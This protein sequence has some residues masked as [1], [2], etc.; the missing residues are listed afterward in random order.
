MQVR[1]PQGEYLITLP[2]L[3][4]RRG[5][6]N[7]LSRHPTE[8]SP[9]RPLTPAQLNLLR[10]R[11][12]LTARRRWL[13]KNKRHLMEQAQAKATTRATEIRQGVNEYCL[14]AVRTWPARMTPKQL[15]EYLLTMPYTRKG[16]KR[17]MKRTSLIRRLRL[18]GL[19]AYVAKANTWHNLCHLPAE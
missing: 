14:E 2:P 8:M 4:A 16:K 6:L 5:V 9:R 18:L 15:D 12:E 3:L 19:I 10:L 11:R 17:R 13:W 7:K 1:L